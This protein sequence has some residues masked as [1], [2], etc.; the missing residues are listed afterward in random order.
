MRNRL[1]IL[2][3]GII[4][5]TS[6][7]EF[8]K[9]QSENEFVPT[10]VQA[11]DEMLLFETYNNATSSVVPFFDLIS[12]DAAVVKFTSSEN[13]LLSQVR[14]APLKAMFTWQPDTYHTMEEARVYE[15]VY[16]VYSGAYSR[17]LGCNAV[18]DYIDTVEGDD[19]D[20]KQ[21]SAE[22]HALRG[23][24]YFHLVNTYGKP[25]YFDK[26]S[27]G[28]P[29]HLTS[30]VSSKSIPRN[31][32][33]EVYQ[34][35]L[36]DLKTAE[37]LFTSISSKWKKNMRVSLPF[38]EL[39]LSRVY[40]YMEQWE[41]SITYAEKV[42]QHTEFRLIESGEFPT[43][44]YMYFHGYTNPEVIWPYANAAEFTDFVDPYMLDRSKNGKV[45]FVIAASGLIEL[46]DET[47]IRRSQYLVPDKRS[48]NYKCFGKL[49][50]T[51]SDLNPDNINHF[52]R[53]FR[54]SEAYLN[55]AEAHAMLYMDGKGEVHKT[56]A[57]D[58]L[59]ILWSKRLPAVPEDYL[60]DRSAARVVNTVRNERRRELCFEDHRWFDLRRYGMNEM[61][62]TWMGDNTD[63]N[64]SV[65]TMRKNDPMYTMPIPAG[66]MLLNTQL[67]QN[68]VGPVR[69]D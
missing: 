61:T 14:L 32:V 24:W 13:D 57:I 51:G 5:V 44:E 55:A 69:N 4:L 39:L 2:F 50:L 27:L 49:A 26:N 54:L 59:N 63:S 34:Q 46:F 47:D 37:E 67:I 38:V 16:D 30:A 36:K 56:K 28:V 53:S 17:I 1:Y 66:V 3:A 31:T 10:T 6:C 35:V 7:E 20:R 12:D 8:L 41:L 29:L 62:H 48:S 33:D 64:V 15:S 68:E 11:L 42:M 21:L 22:A 43:S 25:Y 58:L 19:E 18:L 9:P 65:Y 45:S 52:A 23:L 60:D 40:L